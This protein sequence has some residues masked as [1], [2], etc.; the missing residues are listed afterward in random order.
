MLLRFKSGLT[1]QF[2]VSWSATLATGWTLEAFGSKGR[3]VASAPNFPTARETT[4]R[5]GALGSSKAIEPVEI[6]E[7]LLRTSDIGI[8]FD[9][10]IQP[11]YPMAL[12]MH[13]M[14]QAIRGKAK[15][16]PDFE[17]SWYVERVQE[18]VRRS[19][20]ERRWVKLDEII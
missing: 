14:V 4:L 9:T 10:P 20:T 6:P 18:A 5:A 7:R 1:L 19:S 15:A 16:R 11:A 2:Q 13:N 17:Q 8:A 12:S 3:I